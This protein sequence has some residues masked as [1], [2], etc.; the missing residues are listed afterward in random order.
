MPDLQQGKKNVSNFRIDK[1]QNKSKII[2]E[3][4]VALQLMS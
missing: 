3:C 4:I 1:Q 2:V